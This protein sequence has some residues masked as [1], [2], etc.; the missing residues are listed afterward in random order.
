MTGFGYR[1]YEQWAPLPP[2]ARKWEG[3]TATWATKI[4]WSFPLNSPDLA[5]H[6]RED[7]SATPTQTLENDDQPLLV[8]EMITCGGYGMTG[9]AVHSLGVKKRKYI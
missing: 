9:V 6:G 2:S 1:Q 3:K 7:D 4:S 8:S 5:R